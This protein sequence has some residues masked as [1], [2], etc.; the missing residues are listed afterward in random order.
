[1]VSMERAAL[2]EALCAVHDGRATPQDWAQV[3]AAW[4]SDPALRAR[5]A[6]WQAVGD[7]LRSAEL[8]GAHRDA[9][10]LLDA[11]HAAL[12]HARAPHQRRREWLAPLAVAASF[13]VL[14]MG[15]T[16]WL[17]RAAP[18]TGV[19]LARGPAV[20]VQTLTGTSFAQTAAGRTLPGDVGLRD[21]AWPGEPTLA[22]PDGGVTPQD[23]PS[24]AR[25]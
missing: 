15:I 13:V 9:Q 11:L 14:A 21:V 23:Y 16:P 5:W 24:P 1:M 6:S 18:P 17:P 8:L 25:P 20:P 19:E 12:P 10:P 3:E 22:W 7:G 4:A 2:D